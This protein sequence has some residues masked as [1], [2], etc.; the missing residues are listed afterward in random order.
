MIHL[1]QNLNICCFHITSRRYHGDFLSVTS[2][3]PLEVAGSYMRA[4]FRCGTIWLPCFSSSNPPAPNRKPSRRLRRHILRSFALK[5]DL[6][7]P[8]PRP[9]V[10]PPPKISPTDPRAKRR[11]GGRTNGGRFGR[12]RSSMCSKRLSV[13]RRRRHLFF[14]SAAKGWTEREQASQRRSYRRRVSTYEPAHFLGR[15]TVAE[16]K[17]PSPLHRNRNFRSIP[18]SAT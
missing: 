15:E 10:R 1:F 8:E 14:L 2:F 9:L 4:R 12:L 7:R 18:E 11:K 3:V 5:R 6:N 17:L 13:S 16:K